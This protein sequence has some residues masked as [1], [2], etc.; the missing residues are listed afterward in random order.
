MI[1]KNLTKKKMEGK[2]L[3]LFLHREERDKEGRR[4]RHCNKIQTRRRRRRKVNLAPAYLP[5]EQRIVKHPDGSNES[6]KN[7][8]KKEKKNPICNISSWGEAPHYIMSI[9]VASTP[10]S[11]STSF[12]MT[13]FD[14]K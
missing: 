9:N 2:R 11:Y 1:I 14:H 4:R 13:S 12:I 5:H 6:F 7:P 10:I 8:K 3:F